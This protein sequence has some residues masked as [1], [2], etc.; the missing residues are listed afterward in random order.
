M[1]SVY[2][3]AETIAAIRRSGSFFSVTIPAS[4]SVRTAIA[5]IPDDAWT[6]IRYPSA[7]LDGQLG[8]WVSD[9]EV[10]ETSYTAFTSKKKCLHVTARLIV[11]R[12]RDQNKKAAHGQGELFP[13]WRY[14]AVFTD[15]PFELLQAEDQH[16]GH[17]IIEQV[18]ADLNDGPLAHMPSGHFSANAAWLAIAAMAFNLLRTAGTLASRARGATIRRDLIAVAAR[19]ARHGR[20][21]I[22]LHLPRDWHREHDWRCLFEAACGPP[23]QAT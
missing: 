19:T 17:A 22:T 18:F 11:R 3:G 8:C 12:V 10:A 16:R 4:T 15:S 9:A 14:H 13:A 1:D 21:L 7:I 20:G 6:A 23:A 2:Y 5:A